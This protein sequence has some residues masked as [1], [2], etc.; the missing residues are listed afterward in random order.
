LEEVFMAGM[1]H[2]LGL[3]AAAQVAPVDFAEVVQACM[4]SQT[5]WLAAE[6]EILGIT[7]PMAGARLAEKW[8]FPGYLV[9]VVADHH[10]WPSKPDSSDLA[11]VI[12]LADTMACG[13]A[14]GFTLTAS[15]QTIEPEMAAK[16][17]L[18]QQDLAE[19]W[20]NLPAH[21]EELA[22]RLRV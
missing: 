15:R 11:G 4:G 10:D 3:L 6:T 1:I 18:T 2:D 13:L 8:H 12:W 17:G 9:A 21:V 14:D 20:Q 19:V 7:H 16:L 5:S 22:G